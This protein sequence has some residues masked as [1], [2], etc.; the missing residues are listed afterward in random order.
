MKRTIWVI[1]VLL[2]GLL[3]A[4]AEAAIAFRAASSAGVRLAT[5]S[6]QAS[7]VVA[8]AASGNIT[9]TLASIT[10]NNL[11]IC[12]VEQ[13]DNVAI[14]FPAGWT[15]LYSISATATHRASAFYKMSAAAE[16]NPLI[17]HTGGNSIIAQC[18]TFRGVD[19][20]NPLDVAYA[21][22]YAASSTIVT[23]GSLTTL[24]AN[25][26]MLYAMHVANNPTIT[27]APAGAGGVVW[28]QRFYSSTA[29]GL[30]SATGL[31][32]GPKAVA[33]AVGPI[34]STVSLASENHGVLMALHDGSRLSIQVP[35]GTVAGDVM[36][37]AIATTPS[38]V[39]ITAP[40]GWTLIQAITQAT[41][42]SNRVST[43]YRVATAAEPASYTWTLS[44]A[45]TGAAGGIVSYSGVDTTTPV[46]VSA[47]AA[48]P[49]ALTHAAPTI[50]TTV[51][52]DML[53]T[54]HEYAS[55]R[56]WTPPVGMT[57]RVDIASR[58]ASNAGIT[59]EMNE[60]LL[61]AAGAT[62]AKT[63]TASAS[64]DTGGTVSIALRPTAPPHHIRIEH[65]GG[66]CA[67]A[68]APAQITIKACANVA[69]TAPHYTATDVTGINLAPTGAGY[70]WTPANPQTITA[71]SGGINSGITLA[72]STAGTAT[73]A[74][75][76]TPTPAPSN[77][78]ECYNAATGTSGDCNLVFSTGSF[79]FNVP[80]HTSDSRQV[81]TLTSCK[82]T[83]ASTIRSIKFWSTYVNP[84]TGTQQGKV[85]AG[86]GNAD[87]ATGYSPLGTSS[88][89]P[90]TL[91]LAFGAGATPQATFSLCYPDAGQVQ[92]DTRYDGSALNTPPDAGVVILGNDRFIAAPHHFTLS[93][94]T[95]G[96]GATYV[97]CIV[98]SPY[99]NPAA[100]N[101]AGAAFMKAGNPF[102]MTV[103]AYNTNGAATPNF[104]KETTPE[105][106]ILTPAANMPDLA[107][108][109]AGNLT[110]S[111]GAFNNGV[112]AGT[113]FAY[114]EAGIM[115]VTARLASANYL[116][117]IGLKEITTP[118]SVNIGRFIPDHFG[119]APDP[120]NPDNPI[121][122]RAN[123]TQAA[124][125]VDPVGAAAGSTIIPVLATTGFNVG[126]KIRIP[127][128]GPG[129]NAFTATLLAVGAVNLTLDTPINTALL[130]GE[131]VIEEW[132]SYMDEQFNAQ[133]TLN[134]LELN[135]T[136][137]NN[138]QG[139]YAKLNPAA[140]GNPLGFG[141]VDT[142]APT[143]LSARLN[144]PVATGSF[145]NGSATISAPL[146]IAR[147]TAVT[148]PANTNPN[149]ED[150]P[151]S[152]LKIGIAPKFPAEADDVRMGVYD[153]NVGGG[154]ND[155][156]S[157][158]NPLIQGVTEVRYGRINL[159]NAHGSELLSL[160]I[161]ATVQYWNAAN[162]V[163]SI[164][165]N[166]TQFNTNLSTAGGNVL[167][168]IAKGPLALG[169]VSVVAPGIVTFAN[170]V[171]TFNL[172]A[173]N[174]T[175]SVDLTI[176]TAPSYLLPSTTGRAT[177]GVY[178]GAN[179][180]I[181]LRENY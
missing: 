35:T 38:T 124:T 76:G 123:V 120:A 180:F 68:T 172:A 125:S 106:V 166:E 177:F 179:E 44:A 62:G 169:N 73:L 4:G 160:P 3:A 138:Y 110:G 134:A 136:T 20:G 164:T 72:R 63:A 167:T 142:V 71:L 11:F 83:F 19:P 91:N 152:S 22:Q 17:T 2:S 155:H 96:N 132:G 95:C 49:S 151:Y 121:L 107:G 156:T 52:N 145:V 129:G 10:Q 14:S 25:D 94:I 133:F 53:V 79:T 144:T 64:A 141:A 170:G 50:T 54:V 90:T 103:T 128:A 36:I 130:G 51:A 143:N 61:G 108:A 137:T 118:V 43:Y 21:A 8:S 109:V 32:T 139:A 173:P 41:A 84:A 154:G 69:C 92:V 175:G 89:T 163:T 16:A 88:A 99:A 176:V 57:E 26:L 93:N 56:S 119:V 148:C 102:S 6:Y 116:G 86:T 80:D 70:T 140:A 126:S 24:T 59:L 97:G 153:L 115:T 5:I 146:G 111:F 100:V 98:A 113:A 122:A 40:A 150:G 114:D 67:G 12:L 23:S 34:T 66:A 47:G 48:T 78:Y 55:A 7:G 117:S 147:C 74:I 149:R 178:K 13:H 85:V 46:D 33:G 161:A 1:A 181:Y 60:L 39:P 162:Y 75:T 135:G 165:D 81:V 112:A 37:A 171:N 127:G 18:S 77:A 27:V 15:Q 30:R 58:A 42:T 31:Y 45:H 82:G 157:I 158:M 101:A 104:G 65:N 87:C 9:P 159:A 131:S 174:V 28:T 29:L 168:A 105:G